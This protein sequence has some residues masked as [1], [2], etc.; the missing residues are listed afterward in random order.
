MSERNQARVLGQ[1]GLPSRLIPR[2]Y[3]PRTPQYPGWDCHGPRCV[4]S[5]VPL[6]RAAPRGPQGGEIVSLY[7]APEQQGKQCLYF[8]RGI[9]TLSLIY[10]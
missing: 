7:G 8:S 4:S 9:G 10:Y 2:K 5:P 6:P 3:L 1:L